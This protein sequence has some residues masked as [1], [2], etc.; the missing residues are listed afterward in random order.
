M[1]VNGK[2]EILSKIF[3]V[4]V[5]GPVHS[6]NWGRDRSSLG[7]KVLKYSTKLHLW[8]NGELYFCFKLYLNEVFLIYETLWENFIIF[9]TL[10]SEI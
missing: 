5:I 7:L 6:C 3:M 2:K 10:K 4:D 9:K 8:A 1:N